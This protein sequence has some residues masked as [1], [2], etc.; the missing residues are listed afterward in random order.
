[1]ENIHLH[2]SMESICGWAWH[3]RAWFL[4]GGVRTI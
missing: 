3:F 4:N 1:M 2:S